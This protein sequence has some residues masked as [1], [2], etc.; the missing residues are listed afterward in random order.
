MRCEFILQLEHVAE[1]HLGDQR[2]D[3]RPARRFDE[4]SADAQL[5]A[6][7]KQRRRPDDVRVGFGRDSLQVRYFTR[8]ARS[9]HA[10]PNDQRL[11]SRQRTRDRV[12]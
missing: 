12:R 7:S 5:V 10:R 6:S 8:E 4:L 2:P 1:T 9:R 3:D 11:E